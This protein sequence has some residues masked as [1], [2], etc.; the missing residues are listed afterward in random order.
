ME[1][2]RSLPPTSPQLEEK[3]YLFF[4]KLL[5]ITASMSETNTEKK[6]KSTRESDYY[7]PPTQTNCFPQT[8]SFASTRLSTLTIT[9]SLGHIEEEKEEQEIIHTTYI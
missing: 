9:L 5:F 1:T 6:K 4:K 8:Q 2:G 3:L 7:V